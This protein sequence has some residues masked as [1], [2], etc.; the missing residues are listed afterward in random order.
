LVFIFFKVYHMLSFLL[1][2]ELLVLL[3]TYVLLAAGGLC[4]HA[5]LLIIFLRVRVCESI[6]GIVLFIVFTRAYGKD[7]LFALNVLEF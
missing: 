3:L 1:G 7:Y 4:N 6:L 5:H 2:L